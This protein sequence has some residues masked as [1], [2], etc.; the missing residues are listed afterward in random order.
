MWRNKQKRRFLIQTFVFDQRERKEPEVLK[1]KLTPSICAYYRPKK[2]VNFLLFK[3][4][5]TSSQD[6]LI[7]KTLRI[8]LK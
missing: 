8:I 6:R 1:N 5:L 2:I 7:D 4:F 3:Y